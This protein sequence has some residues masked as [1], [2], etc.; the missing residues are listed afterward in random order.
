[1][2]LASLLA[3][4][5]ADRCEAARLLRQRAARISASFTL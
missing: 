1:M 5:L 2:L 4:A 3:G